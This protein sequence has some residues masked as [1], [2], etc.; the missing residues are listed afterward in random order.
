MEEWKF[1]KNYEGYYEVS[2][3]G[4]VRSVDRKTNAAIKNNTQ[5]TKKGKMLKLSLKRNGY[6]AFDA[7]KENECKTK[8]VHRV[9]AETFIANTE[10]K[11]VVNHKN[12]IKTDNRVSNLEWVTNSENT[13]HAYELGLLKSTKNKEVKCIE[14]NMIFRSSYQAAE[15]LNLTRF[16]NSK[17]IAGMARNIRAVCVGK[18]KSAF[19]YRWID[20]NKQGSTTSQYGVHSSEWK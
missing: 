4:R 6:L 12:G 14:N 8:T 16:K 3:H 15:W 9:I 10:N 11:A 13:Q 19:G 18:T 2:T 20:L 1:V 17:Q 7:S 5:T